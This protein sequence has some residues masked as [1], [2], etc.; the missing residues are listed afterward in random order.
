MPFGR[1]SIRNESAKARASTCLSSRQTPPI[2]YRRCL[3]GCSSST[4][5]WRASTVSVTIAGRPD[6]RRQSARGAL[7]GTSQYLRAET[8]TAT[9]NE[10]DPC[11]LFGNQ[12]IVGSRDSTSASRAIV[13]TT[14]TRCH[15]RRQRPPFRRLKRNGRMGIL[16]EVAR[17]CESRSVRNQSQPLS[18]DIL[19]QHWTA[20]ALAFDVCVVSRPT[21]FRRAVF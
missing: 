18:V 9:G 19:D 1:S 16:N 14:T 17:L 5:R 11:S 8:R 6:K 15:G 7:R 13:S 12:A 4:P 3:I 20:T 10:W 21:R 2:P